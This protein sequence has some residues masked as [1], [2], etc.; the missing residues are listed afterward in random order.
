MFDRPLVGSQIRKFFHNL[1][2]IPPSGRT[3]PIFHVHPSGPVEF[4]DG[5]DLVVMS[6]EEYLRL[7]QAIGE[8]PKGDLI[9]G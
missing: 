2:V 4:L 6:N 1:R 8:Q 7:L 5:T 3:A 9:N